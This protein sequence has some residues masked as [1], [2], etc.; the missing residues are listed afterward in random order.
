VA[1]TLVSMSLAT[2]ET[3]GVRLSKASQAVIARV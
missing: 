3:G 1:R 2:M